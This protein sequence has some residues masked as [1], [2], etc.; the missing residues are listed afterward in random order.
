MRQAFLIGLVV[1]ITVIALV[2][3]F[4]KNY[5]PKFSHSLIK[6]GNIVP[7]STDELQKISQQKFYVLILDKNQSFPKKYL[8]NFPEII[9]KMG[10]LIELINSSNPLFKEIFGSKNNKNKRIFSVVII[11]DKSAKIV[12]VHPNKK[13]HELVDVLQLHSDLIDLSLAGTAL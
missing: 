7:V 6:V 4:I 5:E 3:Y 13:L 2:V 11:T 1:L 10:G 12:G 9:K 8:G